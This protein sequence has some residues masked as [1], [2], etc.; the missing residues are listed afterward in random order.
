M[1]LPIPH[2]PATPIAFATTGQHYRQTTYFVYVGGAITESSRLSA[3]IDRR[4][5]PGWMNFNRY[6]AELYDH[7]TASLDLK[8]GW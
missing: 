3:E 8:T 2:V 5:R 1:S 7:P 6:R 4:I